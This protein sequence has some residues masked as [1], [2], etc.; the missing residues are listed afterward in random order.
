MIRP[1]E[2]WSGDL[3]ERVRAMFGPEGLLAGARN[4]QFRAEQQAMAEKVASSLTDTRHLVV[5]AGTGVGKSLAYLIP[6]IH[7]AKEQGR[8]AVICTQ[9]INLQEQLFL[10]DIPIVEKLLPF[11]FKVALL[12]GR[13]NYICPR[14]LEMAR[15]SASDLFAQNEI[16]ELDRIYEWLQETKDGTLSDFKNPPDFKVWAQVC[17]EP[18]I[19]TQHSC[20]DDPKCFYQ[21][22]RK[23]ILE[24]D[25]VIL[26]HTLFFS[27]LGGIDDDT[28]A[29][30]GYLF[31][32]DF[33]IFDEAHHVEDVASRHIGLSVSSSSLRYLLYR[34]HH[35]RTRKGLLSLARLGRDEKHVIDLLDRAEVFFDEVEQRVNFQ[36]GNEVRV[37][38]PG[39]VED[40]LSPIML[41]LRQR[42]LEA[43]NNFEDDRMVSEFRDSAR[44]LAEMQRSLQAFLEQQHEDYVYWAS[45]SGANGA[46]IQLHGAPVDL[47]EVLKKVLFRDESTA[48]LTS[49]T[50]SV[51]RG[52]EYFQGRVG[53]D[54]SDSLQVDSPFDFENQ[55]EVFI[56]RSMP[57]PREG[58]KYQKALT[59]WVRHYVKKSD[60]KA[61]VLFTSYRLMKDVARN[62]EGW[63]KSQN[64]KLFVQGEGGS[65]RHLLEAFKEDVNSV[66]FGTD[67]FWQGVDVPG[68]ALSNVIITR[69]PFA[70]PDH[71][72]I[73]ARL[74]L[75]EERGGEPFREYSLPEA[76]L[77]FRQGV[78]RLIR[79]VHDKGMIVILDP[80]VISK[81][82]GKA[83]IGKLPKC[84]VHMVND[85]ELTG[86]SQSA[87]PSPRKPKKSQS[88]SEDGM[89]SDEDWYQQNRPDWD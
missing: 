82:Y 17:S 14:R 81:N 34:L 89:M 64:M 69:L 73:Q 41:T 8:K 78:G 65:R 32:N 72:L 53:A 60:G 35:P 79:S 9:T 13:Q 63:F 84:P 42:L 27:C 23:R 51:G 68:D 76:I 3:P 56:P 77:K 39:L 16:A 33:V 22:A 67:S 66:L 45:R 44:R 18:H 49:A 58:E 6:A 19:C 1:L 31:P 88:S 21:Q 38:D 57:E 71:P 36:R 47:A 2:G 75:I 54:D 74:E 85:D 20:G 83:F 87:R 46:N 55:M 5:E 50:L 25:V 26:N 86:G 11:D 15:R 59:Q 30:D 4:F 61:F 29:G 52:L 37:F 80:R 10:K 28:L 70:V 48:I 24:A 7:F 40:S 62:L 12:K 43:A